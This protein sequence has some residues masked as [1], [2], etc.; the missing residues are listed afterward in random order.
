MTLANSVWNPSPRQEEYRKE[1][2]EWD[3]QEFVD[4][5][6]CLDLIEGRISVFSLMNEVGQRFNQSMTC[7]H[8]QVSSNSIMLCM[9]P[10]SLQALSPFLRSAGCRDRRVLKFL[11]TDWCPASQLRVA[12]FLGRASRG[13]DASSLSTTSPTACVTK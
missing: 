12:T 8:V 10:D 5:R 3:F 7:A 2:V 11:A 6:P 1:C 9:L 13:T 4:N